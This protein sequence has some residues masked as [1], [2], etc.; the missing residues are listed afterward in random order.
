MLKLSIAAPTGIVGSLGAEGDILLFALL[1]WGL[2]L[3]S[4]SC[5]GV[6]SGIVFPGKV[7]EKCPPSA[8]VAAAKRTL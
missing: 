7:V 6:R 5:G 4:A 1:G 2:V 3:G 8:S